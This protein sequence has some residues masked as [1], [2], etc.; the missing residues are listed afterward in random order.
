[1]IY[2][3]EIHQKKVVTEDGIAIG[4]LEDFIFLATD[5]P[6]VTKIVVRGSEA[7]KLIISTDYI[8]RINSYITIEKEY[9]TSY[10][11]ENELYLVKNLLDKQ[12]IDIKGNKIV[13]VND[14]AIQDKERLAIAGVDIGLYGLA[15]RLKI[16]GDAVVKL[17]RFFNMKLT[18]EFLSWADI[19][20]LE[21]IRGKVRL[22]GQEEKMQ[23]VRPEDLADYLERTNVINA[24]K[25][26]KIL[27]TE[28]AAEV[29]SNLNINYQTSIFKHFQSDKAA[30]MI[31]FID[32]DEAV[33]VLLTLSKKKREEIM[34]YLEEPV[35]N[36]IE[37]L[38]DFSKN[39]IGDLITT[40][41]LTVAPE[42]TVRQVLDIIRKTT[43][44]FSTLDYVYVVNKKLE[45]V[46]V[47]SLH[48]LVLQDL[49]TPIYKFMTQNVVVIHMTTP[50]EIAVKKMLKYKLY[51]LP[52]ISQEKTIQGIVT[53]DDISSSILKK[54]T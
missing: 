1:M 52:V 2:F 8:I 10:L 18:S 29:V 31:T 34:G 28:K 51:A 43:A 4:H 37:R 16:G 48:N 41:Y 33:D 9:M 40:E 47:F 30:R 12:I 25:F 19:Q 50:L 22:R 32:P 3:S 36:Q 49:E 21:L 24:G 35:R 38:L 6:L 44:D 46:G 53:I 27:D 26:L 15:R 20:P 11:E 45:L 13:R 5:N 14:V 54:F 7:Q 39:P 17:L 42:D 23:K